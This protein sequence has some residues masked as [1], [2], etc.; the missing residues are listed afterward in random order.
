MSRWLPVEQLETKLDTLELLTYQSAYNCGNSFCYK[1]LDPQDAWNDHFRKIPPD[2]DV[3][4]R[5]PFGVVMAVVG[6]LCCCSGPVRF[7]P[8]RSISG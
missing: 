6:L 4:S 3:D 2:D 8:T 5:L 7:L 1:V